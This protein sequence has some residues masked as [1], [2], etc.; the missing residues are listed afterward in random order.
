MVACRCVL[1]FVLGLGG[2]SSRMIRSVS[3]KPTVSQLAGVRRC[4][5]G[6]KFIQQDAQRIDVA[7]GVDVELVEAGLL[8][9]HV[10]ERADDLAVLGEHRAFGEPLRGGL[11]HAEVDDFGDGLAVVLGHQHVR[12]LQVAVD[13]AFL[14]GVLDGVA[15]WVKSS[16]RW[17]T[18][19]CC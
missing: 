15:D 1:S 3:S 12:G 6:Q 2:S 17:R 19:R 9:T 8:G 5:A 16:S 10:F 18:V 11:G 7:A 14:M 13:D 4:A